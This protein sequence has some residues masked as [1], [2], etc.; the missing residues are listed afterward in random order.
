MHYTPKKTLQ[1]IIS[2]ENDYVIPVKGNQPNLLKYLKTQF[3]QISPLSLDIQLEQ[4]RD[5][6][7]Q[8]TVSVLDTIV[9]IES[10]WVGIQRII[11]VE[12][13]GLRACH[14]FTETMFYI[15]SLAIDAVGFAQLIRSHWQA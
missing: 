9:D 7:T 10:D 13:A 8:R 14:P 11:R 2:S 15:S 1:Q 12:R 5:R 3:E 4:C 6:F